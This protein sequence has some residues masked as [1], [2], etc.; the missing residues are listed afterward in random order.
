MIGSGMGHECLRNRSAYQDV[1]PGGYQHQAEGEEQED[2]AGA[3]RKQLQHRRPTL[4]ERI[5]LLKYL[6]RPLFSAPEGDRH[7]SRQADTESYQPKR[8]Q[9]SANYL[10]YVIHSYLLWGYLPKCLKSSDEFPS[11]M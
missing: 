3:S 5:Y 10:V 2:C 6:F 1:Q 7:E 9:H 11:R 4:D 8:Q